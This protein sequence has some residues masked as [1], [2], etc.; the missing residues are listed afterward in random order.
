MNKQHNYFFLPF[1]LTLL[2]LSSC[3]EP[4]QKNSFPQ[5]IASSYSDTAIKDAD[6]VKIQGLPA[7]DPLDSA[8]YPIYS[9][10]IK[11]TGTEADT[12][13]ITYSRVNG[14]FGIPLTAQAYVMPDSIRTIK[15]FGPIPSNSLDS[16]KYQYLDFFVK[17]A[18]SIHV[19]LLK[20][21]I[22][23]HY[24]QTPNGAEQ[25]GTSGKDISVDPAT[26]HK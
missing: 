12:F 22:T 17:T 7:P 15:T 6:Q 3:C 5:V 16:A 23:I 25:C 19:T 18:D 2:L 14:L 26:F 21:Q 24:G 9:V 4:A 13:K 8:Y 11:N 1:G 10:D 20:P